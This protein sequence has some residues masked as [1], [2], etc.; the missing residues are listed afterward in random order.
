MKILK[1]YESFL[2]ERNKPIM[3]YYAFDWDDN[4]LFMPTV[5]HMEKLVPIK[6]GETRWVQEDV[7]TEKFAQVRNDREN[8]RPLYDGD[9]C[10]AYTDFRD[11]GPK[12]PYIFEEDM[13]KSMLNKKFGPSWN[14]FIECLVNG[15][16]FAIITARGHEP[17]TIRN[18]VEF[19][20][21]NVLNNEQR[22]E[23][24][25]NLT[26]FQDMFI[27]NF[28]ILREVSFRTLLSAYLDK[29]DFVGVSSP[30]FEKKH[31][32]GVSSPEEGKKAALNEFVDRINKYGKKVGGEVRLGFSDDDK[33]TLERVEEHFGELDELYDIGFSVIDTS[34]SSV[35]GGI[36]KDI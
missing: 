11:T 9:V 15:S 22:T 33:R 13:K 27:Q 16:V 31:K 23:M 21:W 8:W 5:I 2:F 12:G 20:I 35:Q 6:P 36:K 1:K 34:D 24:G 26:A 19:I 10:L 3:K 17:D 30:S 4:I 25:A 14:K 29:C 32:G 28:D 18:G 7:S